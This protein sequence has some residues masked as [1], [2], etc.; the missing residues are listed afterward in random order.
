MI[1]ACG[2]K[3]NSELYIEEDHWENNV[4]DYD[5]GNVGT[6]DELEQEGN[7]WKMREMR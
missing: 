2:L 1:V 5:A 3:D 6:Q 4:F 7:E